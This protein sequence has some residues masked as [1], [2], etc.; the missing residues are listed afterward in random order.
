MSQMI[1]PQTGSRLRSGLAGILLLLGAGPVAASSH[2]FNSTDQNIQ[3]YWRALGCAGMEAACNDTYALV[4]KRVNLAPGESA[5]YTYKDGTSS[6]KVSIA[7]CSGNDRLAQDS[8]GT[9]NKGDKKRCAVR[10]GG[11][12]DQELRVKC[13]FSRENYQ[14]LKDDGP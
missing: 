10:Y 1:F 3:V 11:E 4:C 9:G 2:V 5:K 13:G 14:S 6:R 7:N 8:A 12:D